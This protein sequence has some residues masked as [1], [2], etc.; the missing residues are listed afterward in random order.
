[1]KRSDSHE[2]IWKGEP[3]DKDAAAY[4]PRPSERIRTAIFD[5]ARQQAAAVTSKTFIGRMIRWRLVPALGTVCILLLAATGI[6]YFQEHRHA[7]VI[8]ATD[9]PALEEM[10]EYVTST[11]ELDDLLAETADN[12][13]DTMQDQF[14][15]ELEVAH[16]TLAWLEVD[17]EYDYFS[18]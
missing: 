12:G 11:F 6:W 13:T 18:L 8:I 15:A 16:E 1:M 17:I 7:P 2:K 9:E 14:L 5:A 3:W 10:V 4:M